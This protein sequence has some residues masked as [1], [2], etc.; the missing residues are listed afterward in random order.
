MNDMTADLLQRSTETCDSLPG[1]GSQSATADRI[2]AAAVLIEGA[3]V[4]SF[5]AS[6]WRYLLAQDDQ[7]PDHPAEGLGEAVGNHLV[8]RWA[9]CADG[10]VFAVEVI[11]RRAGC[12]WEAG[13]SHTGHPCPAGFWRRVH[14]G[15]EGA[16]DGWRAATRDFPLTAL[17]CIRQPTFLSVA[18]AIAGPSAPLILDN[19][20]ALANL[21]DDVAYW[22]GL[23][24][25][26]AP[27]SIRPYASAS[28]EASPEQQPQ[29]PLQP[30]AEWKLG[31]MQEFAA[32]HAPTLVVL[33]RAISAARKSVYSD[34]PLVYAALHLLAETYRKVKLGQE[35][36]LTLKAACEALGLS[37]GGSVDPSNAGEQGDEYFVRWA[38][39]RLFLDQHLAK[40]SSRDPRFALRIYFH[41][42]Q[43]EQRVLVGWL[44]SHLSNSKT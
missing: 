34:P 16:P 40:G 23:A 39:R 35:D 1:T 5:A 9:R 31:D 32:L 12:T 42:L 41:W 29:D 13:A 22:R 20:H 38:G 7:L 2:E 10:P 15:P 43:D 21:R 19:E 36:R 33:P 11:D 8:V 44:P 37:I 17:A 3:R 26:G 30:W 24:R 28:D 18:T 27:R 6:L 14:G 4:Q 25:A